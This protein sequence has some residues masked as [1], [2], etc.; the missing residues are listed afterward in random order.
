[1]PVPAEN[2]LPILCRCRADLQDG[3]HV[4]LSSS[5]TLEEWQALSSCRATVEQKLRDA[6][7]ATQPLSSPLASLG[8]PLEFGHAQRQECLELLRQRWLESGAPASK[9]CKFEGSQK[10]WEE[11]EIREGYPS[12]DGTQRRFKR[13][14]ANHFR[15]ALTSVVR[16]RA[17]RPRLGASPSFAM[18]L[19]AR[20]RRDIGKKGRPRR[21]SRAPRGPASQS[22]FL[23]PKP[24]TLNPK[25]CAVRCERQL[26]P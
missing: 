24:L 10:E 6:G 8:D 23:N 19:D 17:F 21:P 18:L 5:Q 4:I 3:R 13:A 22:Q 15:W 14:C 26:R 7:G 12:F 1:M 11:K 25:P 9:K 2:E 16:R 20:N